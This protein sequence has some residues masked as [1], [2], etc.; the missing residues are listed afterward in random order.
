M[1]AVVLRFAVDVYQNS[2]SLKLVVG[3]GGYQ[4]SATIPANVVTTGALVR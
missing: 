3:T 2:A 4:Y 1:L